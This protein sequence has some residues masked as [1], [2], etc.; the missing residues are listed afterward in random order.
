MNLR[1]RID[2][3]TA[4]RGGRFWIETAATN[5]DGLAMEAHVVERPDGRRSALVVAA[6]IDPRTWETISKAQQ[7]ELMAR[8]VAEEQ[9]IA[10]RVAAVASAE[11]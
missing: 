4:R 6:P 5:A 1:R 9:Q 8:I 2:R 7:A 3:I 10:Q 11:V